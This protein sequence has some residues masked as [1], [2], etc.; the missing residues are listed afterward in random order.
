MRASGLL[1]KL[2]ANGEVIGHR[3]RERSLLRTVEALVLG[4]PLSVTALGRERGGASE[5]K[6]RIKAVDELLRNR[7]L[8]R[9][10]LGIYR[11][12]AHRVLCGERSVVIA[13][14]W[15]DTGRREVRV[16]RATV[17]LE[18]RSLVVW[19]AVY[20]EREYNSAESHAAFLRELRAVL[21][22]GLRVLIVTDAGFRVPWFRQVESYG[23]L[24]LGRIRNTANYQWVGEDTW[25]PVRSLYACAA[26]RFK[27]LGAARLNKVGSLHVHLFR[28][29]QRFRAALARSIWRLVKPLRG[30]CI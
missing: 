16:L 9:E 23:W 13:V 17:A 10:R 6:H 1:R 7:H 29:R 8:H 28:A 30:L 5:E 14:D 15:S 20:P 2:F 26:G 3:M 21:P 4:A 24:W 19:E 25:H 12:M 11:Q 27:A 18:G 22:E